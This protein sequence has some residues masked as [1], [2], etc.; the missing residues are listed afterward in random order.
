VNYCNIVESKPLLI[1]GAPGSWLCEMLAQWFQWAPGDDRGST[2]HARL[3]ALKRAVDN[4]EL[5]KTAQ[6]LTLT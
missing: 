2:E 4:A 5:G 1:A 6:E 3:S